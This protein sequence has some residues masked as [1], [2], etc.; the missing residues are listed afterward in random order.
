MLFSE[1]IG[2]DAVK[3]RLIA[4]AKDGRVSHALLFLGPEGAGNLALTIAFA[5]Y[6]VCE[7]R[8]ETDSCGTCPACVKMNKLV[9][10]DVT[11]SFP[12]ATRKNEKIEGPRSIDYISEWRK[13][14]LE[15]PY[16][17]YNEWVVQLDIEN[18]QGLISVHEAADIVSRLSLKSVESPFRIVIIWYPERLNLPAAN[19]LLKIIEEPPENVFFFLV[20]EQFDQILPTIISRTQLVKVNRIENEDLIRLLMTKHELSAASARK[21]A[22]R[23]DGNYFE[24]QQL[25]QQGDVETDQ[26]AWFIQWMRSCYKFD[27]QE[28]LGF[29]DEFSAMSREQ[30]K[31]RLLFALDIIREC[32]MINYAEN[33]LVKLDGTELEDIKK[34]AKLIN[35]TNAPKFA[36]AINDACFH[37]ERNANVKILFTNLSIQLSG[38]LRMPEL[39]IQPA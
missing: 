15:N 31:G 5:Q 39:A 25:L 22:H 36:E 26:H 38:L 3:K 2:Q 17:N 35:R 14:V 30:Q 13:A 6:M 23:S 9:H 7:N 34:F 33:T 18:K 27:F 16:L 4:S 24:A 11:Y 8:G 10:P 19:K 1:I 21:I 12:V 37:T 32:L 28:I 29:T 20:A